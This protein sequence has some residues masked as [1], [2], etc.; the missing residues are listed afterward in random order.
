MELLALG[1]TVDED[2]DDGVFTD[3]VREGKKRDRRRFPSRGTSDWE[4]DRVEDTM[5]DHLDHVEDRTG[6]MGT[7]KI[8][9]D[10]SESGEDG[11]ILR[12]ARTRAEVG[13]EGGERDEGE[14]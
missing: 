14:G 13:K 3:E 7:N 10:A 5:L 8:G 1:E 4:M 6:P 9:I 12:R 2:E 11:S